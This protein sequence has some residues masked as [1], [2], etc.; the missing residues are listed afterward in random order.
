MVPHLTRFEP[1]RI[2][3]IFGTYLRAGR[4]SE[5]V[6]FRG[7][8][9]S[10]KVP[11]IYGDISGRPNPKLM[12]TLKEACPP[13]LKGNLFEKH[14]VFPLFQESDKKLVDAWLRS[15]TPR[16]STVELSGSSMSEDQFPL[17]TDADFGDVDV[18]NQE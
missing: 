1:L 14:K 17:M 8:K 9:I 4:G 2:M 13:P 11:V 3:T 6:W 10:T 5:S 12:M 7:P 15:K 16:P 18:S